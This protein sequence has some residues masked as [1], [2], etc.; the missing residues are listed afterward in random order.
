MEPRSRAQLDTR[1]GGSSGGSAKS[2]QSNDAAMTTYAHPFLCLWCTRLHGGDDGPMPIELAG[3]A[4]PKGIPDEILDTKVTIANRSKA[5]AVCDSSR[6]H[7]S[8]T[9]T[10]TARSSGAPHDFTSGGLPSISS[11]NGRVPLWH[12]PAAQRAV[13]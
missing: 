11:P 8:L 2:A 3:D 10:W 5:T 4:Y 7:G 1:T 12:R 6:S 9:P 13:Y